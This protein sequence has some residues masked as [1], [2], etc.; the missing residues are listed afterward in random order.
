[1][2]VVADASPLI[3]L[4]NL[5]AMHVLPALYGQVYVPPQVLRE[6]GAAHRPPA[7]IQFAQSKPSWLVERTPRVVTPLPRLHGGECEAISLALELKADVVLLDEAAGRKAAVSLGLNV[8]GVVGILEL[9][10]EA[11]LIDLTVMFKSL[12]KTDFWVSHR[13]LDQR[14]KQFLAR[15]K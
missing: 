11:N 2:I 14:L 6:V 13:F 8:A 4:S 15:R 12:K 10:A 7:A 3:V 9:A 5:G 1:M